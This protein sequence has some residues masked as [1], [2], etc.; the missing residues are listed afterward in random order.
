MLISLLYVLKLRCTH[1]SKF[2]SKTVIVVRPRLGGSNLHPQ[3]ANRE[4]KMHASV[5]PRPTLN[6]KFG[7]KR[8]TNFMD[9]FSDVM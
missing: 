8:A 3:Y 9:M 7:S 2:C 6:I 4:K 1:F 5:Q